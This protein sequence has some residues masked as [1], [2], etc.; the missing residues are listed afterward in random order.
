LVRVRCQPEPGGPLTEAAKLLEQ[1]VARDPNYAPA[2]GLLGQAYALTPSNSGADFTG[3][4]DE[5]RPFAAE[6]LQKAEAAAQQAARLDPNN[7]DGYTALAMVR[8]FGGGFVQAEELYK[9]A[10]SL[11]PETPLRL[12]TLGE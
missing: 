8:A 5:L 1:V 10:L 12:R 11:D 3:S 2:W 6:S 7:I 9:Q 4:N